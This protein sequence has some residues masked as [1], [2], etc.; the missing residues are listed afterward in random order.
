MDVSSGEKSWHGIMAG[1][2]GWI[3][4]ILD[5][6]K[7]ESL[8]PDAM[9]QDKIGCITAVGLLRSVMRRR[10]LPYF[11]WRM[12]AN[13]NRTVGYRHGPSKKHGDG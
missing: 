13:D 7:D 9:I 11:Q 1:E 3:E 5:G 12:L 8:W 2:F 4:G 10:N 6:L